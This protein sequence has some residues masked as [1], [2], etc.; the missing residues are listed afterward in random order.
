MKEWKRFAPV[1]A[2]KGLLTDAYAPAFALYCIAYGINNDA[3]AELDNAIVLTTD[4]GGAKG[5]PAAAVALKSLDMMLKV[6]GSFGCTPADRA[7]LGI[8]AESVQIDPLQRF[9]DG[10]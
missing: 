4:S 5:N 10:R 3:R 8:S 2:E 1:L 7:R 6:L 9:L